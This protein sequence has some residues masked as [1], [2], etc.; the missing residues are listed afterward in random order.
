LRFHSSAILAVA[1]ARFSGNITT[2]RVKILPNFVSQEPKRQPLIPTQ[3]AVV[4]IKSHSET[5]SDPQLKASLMRLSAT[6]T[7]LQQD[8]D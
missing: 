8:K 5:V 3:S 4:A 2:L 1:N 6:L 7:R